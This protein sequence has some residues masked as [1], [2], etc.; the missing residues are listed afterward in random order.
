[1]KLIKTRLRS[2]MEDEFL[3]DHMIVYIEKEI[4]KNFTSEMIMDEFY[5][6]SNRRRA[7][8]EGEAMF[9]GIFVFCICL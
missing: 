5:S 4:A 1:M 7:Y 6:I 3:A 8:F 9:F 2:R